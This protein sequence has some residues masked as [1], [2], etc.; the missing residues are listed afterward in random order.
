VSGARAS[1]VRSRLSLE[2]LYA[3]LR[4]G[5]LGQTL[6][7]IPM[8][9][10]WSDRRWRL[11]PLGIWRMH[12]Q[13]RR[14]PGQWRESEVAYEA[15]SGG[16][17][18]DVGAFEGWYP[19]LLAP[20]AGRGTIVSFEPNP[21]PYRQLQATIARLAHVFSEPILLPMP[22]ALGDG[23]PVTVRDPGGGHPRYGAP[24]ADE[25]GGVVAQHPTVTADR[26]V[27]LLDLAPR[28]VKIDVEGAEPAVLRG[29]GDTL[30]THRPTVMLELHPRYLPRGVEVA[31]VEDPL[32][33]LGYRPRL[34]DVT[35]TTKRCLWTP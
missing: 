5:V 17:V 27:E 16:D 14:F 20:K 25:T 1:T 35:R 11:A 15:Y 24:S 7:A 10:R 9:V 34:I 22:L 18:L 30:S 23:R 4:A 13:W 21:A 19:V 32:R 3:R 8:P 2:A 6:T 33:S 28:F 31:D 12:R 29:M 26:V